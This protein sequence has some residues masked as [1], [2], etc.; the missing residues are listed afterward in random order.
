MT[1][2][3]QASSLRKPSDQVIPGNSWRGTWEFD[4]GNDAD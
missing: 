3:L 1:P 2:T 4:G